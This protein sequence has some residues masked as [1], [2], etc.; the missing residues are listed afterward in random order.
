MK[1]CPNCKAEN[2]DKYIFCTKCK[3][4]LPRVSHLEKLMG[5]GLHYYGKEDW[6]KSME[7]FDALLKL[8]IGNKE[9]WLMKGLTLTKLSLMR[10]AYS[11][12]E[13]AGVKYSTQ[14]CEDCGGFKRCG[15]CGGTGTCNMC[16]GRRKCML[17][18]GSGE[19]HSCDTGDESC[20][21]CKGT[22]TCIRCKGS[23]ECVYCNGIGACAKCHG[24]AFCAT[25]G[26]TGRQIVIEKSS[27]NRD[28]QK[29]V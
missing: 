20:K 15:E 3:R 29:Y 21:A 8:N 2:E 22:R 23:G 13:S 19:C 28:L 17:C 10:E 26:G 12:F 9:A 11:C 27:V 24:N 4:G 1:V 16:N 5:D 18:E 6:R 7:T 25:C 14:R